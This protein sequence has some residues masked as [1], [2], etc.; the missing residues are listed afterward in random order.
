MPTMRI[1]V[2]SLLFLLVFSCSKKKNV[3]ADFVNHKLNSSEDLLSYMSDHRQRQIA[4]QLQPMHSEV[5]KRIAPNYQKY[6]LN[7]HEKQQFQGKQ[8]INTVQFDYIQPNDTIA[9]EIID[10][11][12]NPDN[13]LKS[14]SFVMS[15]TNYTEKKVFD[16]DSLKNCVGIS[17]KK[18]LDGV[19][20]PVTVI[21]AFDRFVIEMNLSKAKSNYEDV[22]PLVAKILSALKPYKLKSFPKIDRPELLGT[23]V[24][25]DAKI[26]DEIN[27]HPVRGFKEYYM[28]NLQEEV[29]GKYR[30]TLDSSSLVR[31]ASP[32]ESVSAFLIK[33]DTVTFMLQHVPHKM[34]SYENKWAVVLGNLEQGSTIFYITKK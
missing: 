20:I 30:F 4:L 19:K 32:S 6:V 7:V 27:N 11:N 34:F 31:L 15:Q 28:K 8:L 33:E 18:D 16:F 24:I 23:W 9:F 12:G 22:S 1:T 5:L 21:Y 26:P 14:V 10:L 2:F 29:Y 13:Y 25:S 17:Y 3:D